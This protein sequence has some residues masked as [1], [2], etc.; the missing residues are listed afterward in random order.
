[1]REV[2]R[3]QLID[4]VMSL[5]G[6]NVCE[7]VIHSFFVRFGKDRDIDVINEDEDHDKERL[8]DSG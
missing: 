3:K 6:E 4:Y 8:C 1:M 2:S 5:G 7:V